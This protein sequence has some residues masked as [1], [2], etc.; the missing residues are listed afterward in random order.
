LTAVETL[1]RKL[2]ADGDPIHMVLTLRDWDAKCTDRALQ[3]PQ[4]KD[5]IR[6]F[7]DHWQPAMCVWINGDLDA[8]LM[9]EID[10]ADLNCILVDATADGLEQISARW[11]PGAM[12]SLLSQ[13]EAVLALDTSAA[14][15]L[16]RAGTPQDKIIVTGAMEDCAPTLPCSDAERNELAAAVGTRPVWL[17]AGANFDEWDQLCTA[18][19]IASRRAHRLLLII[20]PHHVSTA[21]SMADNMRRRGFNVA[22]RSQQPDPVD[23]TQIYIADTE[24]ELGLWYRIAPITFLGG[25]LLGGGCRDPFEAAALGSAVLYGPLVAP[26]QKHATRLN[27]AG[28]SRLIRSGDDLGPIVE[29]LLSAD[30]AAELAHIAWDVTSR[31]ANVTNRIADFIQLRLEELER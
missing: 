29:S 1:G 28:A 18:H 7:L 25:S 31:G 13:F 24:E 30:K 2:S 3:E 9:A 12:R 16:A 6:A 23:V 27:T 22:L 20:V 5:A 17:A 21:Q 8:A 10:H 11:V 26:F 14:Q 4:G 15:K 19:Q